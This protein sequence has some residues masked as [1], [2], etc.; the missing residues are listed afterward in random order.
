VDC[1]KA[2]ECR[3][4]GGGVLSPDNT[5]QSCILM[6]T[7]LSPSVNGTGL[8][9]EKVTHGGQL[10]APF[11]DRDCGEILGNPCI[12]GQWQHVR[13]YQGR[14]HPRDTVT[15][16]HS[17]T[18]KGQF[19]TLMCA[20]L[21][22]CDPVSGGFIP[23]SSGGKF[24]KFALCNPEDHRICGPMPR[25]A[26]ANAI[27][28]TG[29]GSMTPASDNGLDKKNAQWVVFRVYIEDRSEPGGNKPNGAI[30]PSD[31]YCFQAWYTGISV[32]KKPDYSTIMSAFRQTLGGDSCAFLDALGTGE[33]PIGSL[34]NTTV[35]GLPADI[36]DQ[37]P[38]YSGNQQIHPATGADCQ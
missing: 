31:V 33:L 5:D 1:A 25:P 24:K 12:R 26:P 35:G 8:T 34:P 27:I 22:C 10:G 13:H 29:I 14:G 37:G 7:T 36:V 17:N 21:G 11:S 2:V 32:S 16:F 18:P 9:L 3:V 6:V 20:C 15:A 30:D 4:T 19:D 38:L 23:P 28:F